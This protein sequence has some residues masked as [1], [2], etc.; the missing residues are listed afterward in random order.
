[1]Y[2][3]AYIHINHIILISCLY[4]HIYTYECKGTHVNT[5]IGRGR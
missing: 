1:M 2:V 4:I 5:T 3:Y